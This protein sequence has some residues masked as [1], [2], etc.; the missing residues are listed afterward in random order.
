MKVK[1]DL[2]VVRGTVLTTQT[3]AYCGEAGALT[4]YTENPEILV[5]K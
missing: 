3:V 1:V 5:G 4:I 2:L